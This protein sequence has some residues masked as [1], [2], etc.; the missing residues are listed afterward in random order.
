LRIAAPV[1]IAAALAASCIGPGDFR[2]TEHDQCTIGIQH[3][4]CEA[5]GRC[6]VIDDTCTTSGRR[7]AHRAGGDADACV[8][9]SCEAHPIAPVTDDGGPAVRAGGGH[10][11]LVRDG[12]LWCWGRNDHGQVG[13]GSRTP[14]ALPVRVPI[15]GT[16]TAVATGDAHTC[17]ATKEGPVF[18]WGLDDAG[19]LG[20]LGGDEQGFPRQVPDVANATALAAGKDFSCAVDGD[21]R[22]VRCWGD[23]SNGQLGDGVAGPRRGPTTVAGLADVQAVAATWQHACARLGATTNDKTL[24]CWGANDQAQIGD[25]G[26]SGPRGLTDL[27]MLPTPDAS[28]PKPVTAVATGRGH[29]CA[30]AS[31]GLYCWGSNAQGQVIAGQPGGPVEGPRVLE[32]IEFRDP[33][34]VAA[35]AEHTCLVHASGEINCWGANDS[36]QLEI[37]TPPISN[38]AAVVAGDD[39]SCALA[40]DHALYCWGDNRFGQLAIGG[41]TIRS[42]PV[43]VPG[44]VHA[45]ALAAGGAHTCVT[46]D[47]ANGAR[48]LFCWGANGSSQLGNGSSTDASDA[49]RI[50]SLA[51]EGIAAGT[52]HTCAFAASHQLYCWGAGSSGQLGLDPGGDGVVTVPT[53]KDLSP[54]D[55]GDDVFAV[56]AGAWH[57]CV[58]ATISASVLC[59]GL[60]TDGQLGNPPLLPPPPAKVKALAAGDAHSCALDS[61]GKVWCWGRGDQGQLGDGSGLGRAAPMTVTLG[62]TA[63]PATGIAAGAEHTCAIAGG[64]VL[65]WG[66]N[67]EGQVG[68]PSQ[69][70]IVSPTEVLNLPNPGAIAAGGRHTCA[71]ADDATVR[72][73]GAN[74]SGQLG[75][76][77]TDSRNAPVP[78]A[79]LTDVDAVVAGG[80]HS[81]ARRTDGSVWCWG[82]NTSGQLGDGITLTSD[83][84]LLARIACE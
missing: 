48:A 55:G 42:T 16:V 61:T 33:I 70:P 9:V 5:N 74:E 1:A 22:T 28:L 10:A 67:A 12:G 75:N 47:D 52:A 6:S 2:C 77:D 4:F 63:D 69:I 58:A 35:G 46:A 56:A 36:R 14:R 17:A 8:P 62:T 45:G 15:A 13:D 84:A 68:T 44:I 65:C 31:G 76:G 60:D 83:R 24:V 18:C 11:C 79:G 25:G 78:V 53:M 81:C 54:P 41:G 80:S 64:K 51:P 43:Q 19:Q 49:T 72:C 7:Y 37:G 34:S 27:T 26:A 23:D 57:T 66:R 20:D 32:A 82:A 38:A 71:V 39:F 73:W 29:T 30:I 3:G 21:T 50:S 59:F 40:R